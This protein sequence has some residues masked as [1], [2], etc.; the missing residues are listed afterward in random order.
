MRSPT[1]S[2]A[3]IWRLRDELGDLL[4]Q[5]VFHAQMA[6]EAARFTFADVVEAIT[7]K[8]IR[9]HPHVFADRRDDRPRRRQERLGP[10]QGRGKAERAA[11]RPPEAPT[12]VAARPASGRSPALTRAMKLQRKAASVGFDWNDPRAVLTRSEE[13]AELEAASRRDKAGVAE[14]MG[15]LMFAVVN[16][17]RHVGA[18]PESRAARHQRKI[19]AAVC[20]YR[21]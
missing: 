19:R 10:H 13:A 7:D 18:D 1:R 14:E 6:E 8:M 4:F 5:V 17:A 2:S 9:R 3:A 15:D 12:P 21:A 11:R 20:G 16:V